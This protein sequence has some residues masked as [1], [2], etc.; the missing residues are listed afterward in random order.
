MIACQRSPF[1]RVGRSGHS[2]AN[3]SREAIPGATG[4]DWISGS[5]DGVPWLISWP[6]K[7]LIK[8]QLL[9][10]N[11]LWLPRDSQPQLRNPRLRSPKA[12]CKFRLVTR[13]RELARH[14]TKWLAGHEGPWELSLP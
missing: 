12:G 11:S 4:F 14:K 2:N 3:S 13:L 7:K 9:K 6:R 8:Q 10:S 1:W 5:V